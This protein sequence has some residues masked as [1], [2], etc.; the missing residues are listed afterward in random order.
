MAIFGMG[1]RWGAD[2][3]TQTFVDEGVACIGYWPEEAS[4]YYQMFQSIKNG[5]IIYLKD[6]DWKKVTFRI[7]AIGIVYD[8]NPFQQ[9]DYEIL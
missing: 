6:S 8:N 3:M 2:D 9:D 5:D 7:R 1:A 4:S